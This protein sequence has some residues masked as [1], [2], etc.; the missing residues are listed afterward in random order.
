[1]A[2]QKDAPPDRL[3]GCRLQWKPGMPAASCRLS[4]LLVLL[5]VVDLGKFRIDNVLF[6]AAGTL[7]ADAARST[8]PA[9]TV[10]RL[11]VHGLAELHRGLRQRVG[12]GGDGSGI[13]ALQRFLEIGD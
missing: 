5:V 1:M 4:G 3:R 2:V 10:L 13:V 6:L 8:G 11:L 12:L 7:A 9:G